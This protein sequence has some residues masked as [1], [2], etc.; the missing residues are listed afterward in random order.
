M[1]AGSSLVFLA[2]LFNQAASHEIL[3]LLVSA[4]AEHLFTAAHGIADLEI[5][6]N[7]LE[8][9]VETK[10]FLLSKDVAKLIGN[11]VGK[12]T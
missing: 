3:E 10:H 1:D 4:Q 5:G 8:E 6:E 9:I 11:M 2:Q 12:A 7:A